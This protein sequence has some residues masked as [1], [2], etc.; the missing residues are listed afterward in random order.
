MWTVQIRDQT[1]HSVQSDLDLHCPQKLL[2][3]SSVRKK[4]IWFEILKDLNKYCC[5]F[6]AGV[7]G[8]IFGLFL[9]LA[10]DDLAKAWAIVIAVLFFII[11]AGLVISLGCQPQNQAAITFKVSFVIQL[12]PV[13]IVLDAPSQKTLLK[14]SLKRFPK[15]HIL[16]PSKMK[17]FADNNFKFDENGRKFSRQIENTEEK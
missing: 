1:A 3:S 8:A 11:L 16:D 17:E 9:R 15:W 2:V 10:E 4:F 13:Q 14:I 6:L 7:V 12:C 5:N